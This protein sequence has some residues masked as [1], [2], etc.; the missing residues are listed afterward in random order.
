MVSQT[1]ERRL[2]TD[3]NGGERFLQEEE[4][5]GIELDPHLYPS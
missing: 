5:C 4:E 1:G 2:G 3:R